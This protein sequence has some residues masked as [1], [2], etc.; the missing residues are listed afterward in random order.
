M[1]LYDVCR[2]TVTNWIKAGLRPSDEKRPYMFRGIVLRDFHAKDA[3]QNKR[4]LEQGE[5]RCGACGAHVFP[6]LETIAVQNTKSGRRRGQSHCPECAATMSKLLSATECDGLKKGAIPK[7]AL[8][9]THEERVAFEGCLRKKDDLSSRV[10]HTKNDRVIHAWQIFAGKYDPKTTRQHLEAIRLFEGF[11]EGKDFRNVSV[12]DVHG[13]RAHLI[14]LLK[15]HR[16]SRSSVTH[17]AS[18]VRS[19]LQWLRCQPGFR[20]IPETIGAYLDLPKAALAQA[21]TERD[22]T[23]A[24]MQHVEDMIHD[25]P[26]KTILDRRNQ[27]MIAIGYLTCIRGAAVTAL[28]LRHVDIEARLAE[29]AGSDVQGKNGKYYVAYFFPKA[30]VFENIVRSWVAEVEALGLG[31]NDALFPSNSD[32]LQPDLLPKPIAPMT[33]TTALRAAFKD[34]GKLLNLHL[35]PH[36]VRDT[37]VAFGEEQWITPAQEKAWSGNCGHSSCTT[38]RKYYAKMSDET[39][40]KHLRAMEQNDRFTQEEYDLMLNYFMGVYQRGTPEHSKA[41]ELINRRE[42][43]IDEVWES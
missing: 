5:F 27:A 11:L 3:Q 29:H 6:D 8:D 37:L 35:V 23:F 31:P 34:F 41:K 28:R 2:D 7:T 13:F 39:R 38:T 22:R 20:K 18:F 10:V 9:H 43:L 40:Q 25:L 33:T 26:T 14:A 17:K 19:F 1:K 4:T 36:S 32:L 30:Q 42:A 24:A 16:L 21:K 15:D 12:N